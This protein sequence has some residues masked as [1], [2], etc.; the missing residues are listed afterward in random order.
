MHPVI[1]EGHKRPDG[2]HG[3]RCV[4]RRWLDCP[5]ESA[6]PSPGRPIC[7]GRYA[8]TNRCPELGWR[9]MERHQHR[10]SRHS[11]PGTAAHAARL[12]L[13]GNRWAK[14]VPRTLLEHSQ[15][16]SD[17][18]FSQTGKAFGSDDWIKCCSL[19]AGLWVGHQSRNLMGHVAGGNAWL[20]GN[21]TF[22]SLATEYPAML[23]KPGEQLR[24]LDLQLFGGVT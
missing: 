17:I 16:G 8:Q 7:S 5:P 3:D 20:I 23:F 12:N 18:K 10:S 9:P 24:G 11:W 21:P 1:I 13:S 2:G 15:R 22:G 6:Q 19:D 14:R 4:R